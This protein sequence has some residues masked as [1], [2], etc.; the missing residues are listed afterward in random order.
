MGGF[1][2]TTGEDDDVDD[3][4]DD[5]TRRSTVDEE[6]GDRNNHCHCHCP[7]VSLLLLFFW[8]A[9]DDDAVRGDDDAVV[10]VRMPEPRC[11]SRRGWDGRRP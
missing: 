3:D 9:R 1:R 7:L 6:D 5:A 4:V 11:R 8:N 2:S 10:G